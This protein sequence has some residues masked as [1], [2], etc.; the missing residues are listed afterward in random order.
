VTLGFAGDV[1]FE[2]DL[3]AL[4]RR[5]G[6]A[7]QPVAAALRRP[8]LMML[9]LE[10][11]VT[12]RG[13]P[14]P[15]RY[16]F[17]SSPRTLR[18]L[19]RAG[20]DVVSLA[21]NHAVDYGLVGLRDT[22]RAVRRSPVPVVGIGRDATAAF[23]PLE[24]SLRGTRVSVLAATTK[25]ERTARVW[26]AGRDKPGVA[27]AVDPVPRLLRTVRAAASRSDVVVV[28]LHWGQEYES[29][30]NRRVRQY[31]RELSRAG[32]DVVV[33]SH[34]H[35]LRGA[36]WRSDGTYV[37]YG[38][39]NFVWY[40]QNSVRTGIL[41]LRVRGHRVV[42]DAFTPARIGADGRPRLVS[43]TRRQAAVD[44]WRRLRRC[45]DL[46]ATPPD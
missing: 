13:S 26:G 24:V 17:R 9:N 36:G 32:A 42:A 27:A 14:E 38:M 33:G 10:A 20:V 18:A 3:A 16:T 4:L 6:T 34:S 30:P 5:P 22:L 39:G 19:D 12:R 2:G 46:A 11:A 44:D 1:H 37:G 28:Y 8:D 29:C 7:L 41:T 21:N 35:V 31:A 25:S 40:N 15:K 43:G 23:R 45:T